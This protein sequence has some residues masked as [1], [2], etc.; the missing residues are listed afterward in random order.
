MTTDHVYP[1]PAANAD[2]DR[3]L[4][5]YRAARAAKPEHFGHSPDGAW[6]G[7]PEYGPMPVM[8]I[9][10]KTFAWRVMWGIHKHPWPLQFWYCFGEAMDSKGERTDPLLQFDI[11]TLPKKYIGRFQIEKM[12]GCERRSHI[13]VLSRAFA[14]GFDFAAHAKAQNE[15]AIVATAERDAKRQVWLDNIGTPLDDGTPF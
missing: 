3:Q 2:I 14:D 10:T 1:V 7:T 9:D 8:L 6:D 4:V 13:S 5:D 11:R 12:N 15:I